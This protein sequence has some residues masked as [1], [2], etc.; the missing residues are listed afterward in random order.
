MGRR[1]SIFS[2][3]FS[4]LIQSLVLC[5]KISNSLKCFFPLDGKRK[6]HKKEDDTEGRSGIHQ[7]SWK[8]GYLWSQLKSR[9]SSKLLIASSEKRRET[10]ITFCVFIF[11]PLED[12]KVPIP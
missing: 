8:N 3:L 1:E 6:F 5:I 10:W 11:T 2:K 4:S 12:Y 7:N 9:L